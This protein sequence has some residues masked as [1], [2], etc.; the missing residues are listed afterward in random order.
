MKI[1]VQTD[2]NRL[3][4]KILFEGKVYQF[5]TGLTDIPTHRAYVQGIVSRIELDMMGGQFDPT[6]LK[7]RPKTVGSNPSGVTCAQLFER[8]MQHKRNEGVSERS[9]ETRYTPLL[10]YLERSLS[11]DV[12]E[13]TDSRAKNFKA[14][15]SERLTAQTTKAHL[16]LLQSCWNWAAGKYALESNPW[17]GLPSKVKGQPSQRVQ[18]FTQAEIEAILGAFRS[19]KYYSHYSDFVSFLFGT[20]CGFGEGAALRWEHITSDFES[21]WIGCSYSRGYDK[22]TKTGRGRTIVLNRAMAAMLR[23]RREAKLIG[24][25]S[26]TTDLVFPSPTGL[27]ICDWGFRNRAWFT[28]L[29]ECG[30]AYRK[31]YCIRHSVI[32]HALANG[33]N[34]VELAKQTGHSVKVLLETYAHVIQNRSLFVEFVTL[35]SSVTKSEAE[36]RILPL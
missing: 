32:S 16:W 29:N 36:T 3:R 13:V 24:R 20:A 25:N 11:F 22:S 2:R 8:F 21:V 7:Y 30:V 6:L 19:H 33:A 15:L 5:S 18:P 10:K 9:L 27:H 26:K 34:P 35:Q 12:R 31:P 28:V 17:N 14:L 23:D 4:I 1:Y